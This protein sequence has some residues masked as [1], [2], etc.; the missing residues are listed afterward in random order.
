MSTTRTLRLSW[1]QKQD[2][3]FEVRPY[4]TKSSTTKSWKLL[5]RRMLQ[6]LSSKSGRKSIQ[7]LTSW[8]CSPPLKLSKNI[9]TNALGQEYYITRC[10][11]YFPRKWVKSRRLYA[12]RLWWKFAGVNDRVA[13]AT[14]ES[15]MRRRISQQHMVNGVSFVNL[16]WP[17]L[18]VDGKLR[19]K[20]KLKQM[21]PWKVRPRLGQTILTNGTYIVDSVIG[22]RTVTNPW[23]KSPV[24]SLDGV[25]VGPYAHIRPGSSLAK[26]VHVG[27]FVKLKDRQL[28]RKIPGWSFDLAY[29]QL[30]SRC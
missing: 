2:N 13:L 24:Y 7:G 29:W 12:E 15:V 17:I 20:F 9:N 21:W 5:S 23:L 3:P 8:Q 22:E 19:L 10:D 25:T 4:R 28:E 26:D 11:W 16:M 27:N 18:T 1:Q 14:A 30:W 6:T